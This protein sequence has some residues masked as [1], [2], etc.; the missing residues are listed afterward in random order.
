MAVALDH[1]L[2]A[3]SECD[4]LMIGLCRHS[5]VGIIEAATGCFPDVRTLAVVNVRSHCKRMRTF[6]PKA[7][8]AMPESGHFNAQINLRIPRECAIS[9]MHRYQSPGHVIFS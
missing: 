3:R 4:W 8:S 7:T 5:R 1:D 2:E 9:H 6:D